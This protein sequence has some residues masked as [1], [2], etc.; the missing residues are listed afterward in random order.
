MSK[1]PTMSTER[2]AEIYEVMLEYRRAFCAD[3]K[4]FKMTELWDHLVAGDGE[5]K[6]QLFRSGL[7]ADYER[8]A[9]VVALGHRVT[10]TAD[11]EL[12]ERATA[13]SLIANFIL[14][15]EL[16]H[17]ALDHHA[18]AAVVKNFKLFVGS[19]G[20]MANIPPSVEELEAHLAAVFLQCGVALEDPRWSA[21]E[22]AKRA[23]SDVS[24]VKKCQ[25]YVRLDVAPSA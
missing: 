5:W 13:G 25:S 8:R 2:A 1:T 10:L 23:F 6:I 21:L 12:W 22:L 19:K 16:G 17:L 4:F 3:T 9:G 7:G 24:Y 11:V 18:K 14:G 20:C 15:H